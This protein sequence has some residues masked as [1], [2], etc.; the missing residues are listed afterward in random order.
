MKKLYV[1]LNAD[2]ASG[3]YFGP[4]PKLIKLPFNKGPR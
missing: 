4:K 2:L 1:P 3:F